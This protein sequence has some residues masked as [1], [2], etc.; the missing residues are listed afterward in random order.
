MDTSKTMHAI[1]ANLD[2]DLVQYLYALRII[3]EDTNLKNA[4]W[5]TIQAFCGANLLDAIVEVEGGIPASLQHVSHE[6][7][8]AYF[9]LNRSLIS[10]FVDFLSYAPYD[11][12][13]LAH[14]EYMH[15]TKRVFEMPDSVIA[16]MV[17]A[18]RVTDGKLYC[19]CTSSQFLTCTI[20]KLRGEAIR[21]YAQCESFST[22]RQHETFAENHNFHFCF[23]DIPANALLYDSFTGMKFDYILANPPF[24]YSGWN[25]LGSS[26]SDPRWIYSTPPDSNA[27]F[28]WIQHV[29]CHMGE[30]GRAALILPNS[31]LAGGSSA[32]Q[33][34]RKEIILSGILSAVIVFP[35]K[36]FKGT[37]TAFCI[38][39][40]DNHRK[41]EILFAD[42]TRN[43]KDNRHDFLNQNMESIVK[44]LNTFQKGERI[45]N[46]NIYASAKISDIAANGFALQP[47]LYLDSN[48]PLSIQKDSA[49]LDAVIDRILSGQVSS[50]LQTVLQ[51][52]RQ[53]RNSYSWD[54]APLFSLYDVS[55]GLMKNKTKFGKGT[56]ILNVK[57]ILQHS[58][59]PEELK[60]C[61]EIEE[62]EIQKY[63]IMAG[64]VFLNRSSENKDQIACCSVALASIC[65]VFSGWAKRLRPKKDI[66]Y[67]KYAAAYFDSAVYRKQIL[68]MLPAYST[69]VNINDSVL[70][71]VDFYYPSFPMQCLIGDVFYEICMAYETGTDAEQKALLLEL[72]N[73]FV[74]QTI[75]QPVIETYGSKEKNI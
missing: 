67:P 24:N 25:P 75:S 70:Q 32:E 19:P 46:S 31:T 28:A 53:S 64:D 34:I 10:L 33:Y 52:W 74:E 62:A 1:T 72:K 55:V 60:E 4:S 18:L 50:S 9:R 23:S 16:C 71:K 37:S 14:N 11:A 59:V 47:N 26:L 17:D 49:G 65:A 44:I 54:T 42:L 56:K 58:F 21:I 38:W 12:I 36:L 40:L 8:E 66:I 69:R 13:V 35:R 39:L 20:D 48:Y 30:T 7:W 51:T 61:V 6:E 15:R 57:T 3:A 5:K 22:L 2:T 63:N 29:I 43:K 68:D 27:N 41:D 73:I 45:E